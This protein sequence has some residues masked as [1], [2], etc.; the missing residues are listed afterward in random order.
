M[1]KTGGLINRSRYSSSWAPV[2]SF[3]WWWTVTRTAHCPFPRTVGPFFL[4]VVLLL[5]LF[6]KTLSKEIK[7]P[8]F[9]RVM[10]KNNLGKS[11][12]FFHILTK[13]LPLLVTCF[14]L[15]SSSFVSRSWREGEFQAFMLW[16][17]RTRD[18]QSVEHAVPSEGEKK[19]SYIRWTERKTCRARA[20]SDRLA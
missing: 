11:H 13:T 3:C 16:G 2:R 5:L 14:T 7:W 15:S 12:V 4:L 10:D 19:K 18:C 6:S 17:R 20:Q 8:S 1:P 9:K